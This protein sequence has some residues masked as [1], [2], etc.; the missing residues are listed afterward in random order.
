MH[1][2]RCGAKR[3]AATCAP[4]FMQV[5]TSAACPLGRFPKTSVPARA[6]P[7]SALAAAARAQLARLHL[8][9]ARPAARAAVR[10]PTPSASASIRHFS[11]PT[12]RRRRHALIATRERAVHA[13][14]TTSMPAR[15]EARAQTPSPKVGC[16]PEC[17]RVRI[18]RLR[19]W[20]SRR[21]ARRHEHAEPAEEFH[22][23]DCS[24]RTSRHVPNAGRPPARR[25][26]AAT[27]TAQNRRAVEGSRRAGAPRGVGD[28]R[29]PAL[30]RKPPQKILRDPRARPSARIGRQ[31]ISVHND[32]RHRTG[33][34]MRRSLGCGADVHVPKRFVAPYGLNAATGTTA[35]I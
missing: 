28:P 18:G 14:T 9:A 19:G 26:V 16:S 31:S 25:V 4:Q 29:A 1:L 33:V 2:S 3:L 34:T 30:G 35:T 7:P 27:R 23:F 15:E 11:P 22:L 8:H 12:V 21:A 10:T 5:T 24:P 20:F 17:G 32:C 6:R 13:V